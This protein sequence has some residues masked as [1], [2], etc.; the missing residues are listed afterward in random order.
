[1]CDVLDRIENK[2]IQQGIQQGRTEQKAQ[3]ILNM[4]Q[5]GLPLEQIA[6]LVDATPD[7]VQMIVKKEKTLPS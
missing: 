1:M 7:E 2:G 6:E 5:K 3:I 4:Y